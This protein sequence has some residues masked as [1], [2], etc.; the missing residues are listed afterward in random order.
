[1][2]DF[3]LEDRVLPNVLAA[4]AAA[5]PEKPFILFRDETYSYA[6][7]ELQANQLAHGMQRWGVSRGSRVA[8]ILDNSPQY[9]ISLFAI[10]KLGALNVPI[11]TAARGQLLAYF[12]TDCECTHVIVQEDYVD[13][14]LEAWG[15][16]FK[17]PTAV[18]RM[19]DVPANPL[20]RDLPSWSDLLADGSPYREKSLGIT[21]RASDPWL[22]LYTSGTTGPSKGSVC[23]HAQSLTIG[24]TQSQR[25]DIDPSDRMYTFLPLFH[26]NALNYSTITALWGRAC[27]ALETRFSASRFWSDVHRYKATQFNAMMIVTSV[28]E[29]LPVTPEEKNNPVR[30]A[31]MVPPPANRRELEKRWGLSI[32]SQ[33]AM[34]EAHPITVLDAGEAYDKPR[35]SGRVAANMELRIVDEN[36]VEV[37]PGTPGEITIRTREPWTMLLEYY[38]KPEATLAAFRNLWF[39]TGDRAY[40][41]ED[42]YLFFVDRVKDAIRRRGENIS[43]YE[44]EVILKGHPDIVEAAAIPVPSEMGEDEVA[45]FVVRRGNSLAEKDI[46]EFAVDRM[47]YYMVPRFVQ[48]IDELPKTPSQKVQKFALREMAKTT[49]KDMWDREKAGVKVTRFTAQERK[50]DKALGV[51]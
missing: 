2:I 1:M 24:R 22:I 7:T 31:V 9:I 5:Q 35:T 43:A 42:G 40:L 51:S 33:F 44:I 13:T 41:D 46:V 23:P 34:S 10:A 29:K 49:Y 14:L 6:E 20:T 38:G 16:T 36:D 3:A 18:M 21:V 19:S 26:G 50:R 45:I 48:F 39:H 27:I 37:P 4:A 8:A 17:V 15:G 25:M 47:A 12:L 11:N 28:L 30:I 32:I